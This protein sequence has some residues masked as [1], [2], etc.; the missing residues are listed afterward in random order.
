MEGKTIFE[1]SKEEKQ[2]EVTKAKEFVPVEASFPPELEDLKERRIKSQCELDKKVVA[3]DI[4]NT[5]LFHFEPEDAKKIADAFPS[6][7]RVVPADS[8]TGA[9]F[10]QLSLMAPM[11]AAFVSMGRR[12]VF[13]STGHANLNA[14]RLV[15]LISETKTILAA[16]DKK[17]LVEDDPFMFEIISKPECSL[18]EVVPGYVKT[19]KNLL[20]LAKKRSDVVLIDDNSD[21][22]MPD[23]WSSILNV[24]SFRPNSLGIQ[25]DR[26]SHRDL[27]NSATLTPIWI[28]GV[29]YQAQLFMEEDK[30]LQFQ[31]AMLKAKSRKFSPQ[32]RFW[33]RTLLNGL[34]YWTQIFP[35]PELVKPLLPWVPEQLW[36][37][38]EV[39]FGLQERPLCTDECEKSQ[40]QS[41][42]EWQKLVKSRKW[43]WYM[44]M[45]EKCNPLECHISHWAQ[46]V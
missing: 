7:W 21:I 11:L 36:V 46:V 33:K 14:R 6:G 40:C 32:N 39:K 3:V 26:F 45:S 8:E 10:L 2:D 25:K 42:E 12:V 23:D 44:V 19:C 13:F 22:E 43:S 20:R 15:P 16:M 34:Q 30:E 9:V 18:V 41:M 4:D 17:K 38:Q 37:K 29:M 1:T 5:I 31:D 28:M 35:L 27:P 24:E